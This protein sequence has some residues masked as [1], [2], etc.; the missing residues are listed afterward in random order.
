[1]STPET[2]KSIKVNGVRL[3]A[4]RRADLLPRFR[5]YLAADRPHR[6]ATVNPEFIVAAD[7]DTRFKKHLNDSDLNVADGFGVLLASR[8]LLTPLPERITGHDLV[9]ELC[10]LSEETGARIYLFGGKGGQAHRA[11]ERL[12]RRYPRVALA[13]AD[14]ERRFWGWRIPD[15]VMR[16]RI[17]RT[18]P[19]ILLVGLGAGKQEQWIADALP[20]LPS[21]RI[22]VGVGGAFD[23]ISGD[24][25]RGP[26]LFRA[27]G[28]EWA[29][30]LVQE[31]HRFQRIV[32]A[33]LRFPATVVRFRYRKD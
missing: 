9:D 4:V 18:A 26:H 13:G 8:F 24:L 7:H 32:T 19:Q 12:K 30:R 5:E 31:P 29:W 25:S 23:V 1:M 10:R 33:T 28:L 27:L 16:L 21:V 3:D 20:H 17:A 11:A 22:A 6:I 15:A 2:G 14:T